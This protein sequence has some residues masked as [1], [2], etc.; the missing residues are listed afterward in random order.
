M[1]TETLARSEARVPT[2]HASRYLQQLCKH[3]SHK[4]PVTF[5]A[6]QG[7]VSFTG[8]T[9]AF[10]ASPDALTVTVTSP[11]ER[12]ERMEEVVTKHLERFAFREAL[13]VRWVR[14]GEQA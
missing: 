13:D 3:W 1:K 9:C 7:T 2:E 6:A 12:L 14:Q 4:F 8:A 5:D 10:R 11:P